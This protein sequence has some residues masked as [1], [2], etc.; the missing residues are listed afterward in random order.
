MNNP[1]QENQLNKI[2]VWDL[3]TRLFHWALAIGFI[4]SFVSIKID[5]MDLHIASA[6]CIL[7]LL[8]FRLL[9]GFFGSRTS[10]F[11]QFVPSPR[12]LL[13]YL[14]NKGTDEDNIG[15]SP[16]G[17]LSVIA[18][19]VFMLLQLLTGLVADDEIYTTGPLRDWVS[20][21]FSSWATSKHVLL[22]DIL[23]GLIVLHIVAILFYWA[24]KR[25]NL[26]KPMITG[27]KTLAA[28]STHNTY[29]TYNKAVAIITIII[30][31]ACAYGVFNWL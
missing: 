29:G 25:S 2:K 27:Y 15:H 14:K 28:N 23:Q 11:T 5:D 20:S 7:G 19:L 6:T 30:A 26:I 10:R 3:P 18:L 16:L 17:A 21:D 22:A 9:W 24:V 13:N 12:R 31:A 1:P 4:V 8:V